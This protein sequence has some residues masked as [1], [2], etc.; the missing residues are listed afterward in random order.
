MLIYVKIYIYVHKFNSLGAI[1]MFSIIKRKNPESYEKS[2]PIS[3]LTTTLEKVLNDEITVEQL[4]FS[5]QKLNH[6]L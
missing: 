3:E 5:D 4:D 1:I 2:I 6:I